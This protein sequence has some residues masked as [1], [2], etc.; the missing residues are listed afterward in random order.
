M[1]VTIHLSHLINF[2]SIWLLVHQLFAVLAF[3]SQQLAPQPRPFASQRAGEV[4]AQ[5]RHHLLLYRCCTDRYIRFTSRQGGERFLGCR[6][7]QQHLYVNL[8]TAHQASFDQAVATFL[9]FSEV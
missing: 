2:H 7:L 1:V 5:F 9:T 6:Q 3:Q 8:V 4:M